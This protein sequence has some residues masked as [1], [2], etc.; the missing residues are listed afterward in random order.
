MQLYKHNTSSDDTHKQ[1]EDRSVDAA[2]FVEELIEI[3]NTPTPN[4]MVKGPN[5]ARGGW[6]AYLKFYKSTR[7][8]WLVGQIAKYKL[9]L[10]LR[11][12]QATYPI[13]LVAM[14]T[15]HTTCY[16]TTH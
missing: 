9:A 10:A 14:I 16:D 13:I 11:G 15:R 1:A 5:M 12:L 3:Y 7:A 6:I 2:L 8:I 4:T